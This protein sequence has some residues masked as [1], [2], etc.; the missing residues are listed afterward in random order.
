[1]RYTK[2]RR[3][4]DGLLGCVVETVSAWLSHAGAIYLGGAIY[5]DMMDEL[6]L[7]VEARGGI[8]QVADS[9][10]DIVGGGR[11]PPGRVGKRFWPIRTISR[12]S[13]DE[14]SALFDYGVDCI[15]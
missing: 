12:R 15:G 13:A 10:H 14:Q 3:R 11:R 1:M 7:R 6:A 5:N 2:L 4:F 8:H 9:V